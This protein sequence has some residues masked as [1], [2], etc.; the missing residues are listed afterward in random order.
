MA[1]SI[2]QVVKAVYWVYYNRI[3]ALILLTV[4]WRDQPTLAVKALGY[5]CLKCLANSK[6]FK[7]CA[8]SLDLG[9]LKLINANFPARLATT[10]RALTAAG[11]DGATK[12]HSSQTL[13]LVP[14]II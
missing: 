3:M 7:S 1:G 2:L 4:R 13:G 9:S 12:S 8:N 14:S 5:G 6:T 11:F 10:I